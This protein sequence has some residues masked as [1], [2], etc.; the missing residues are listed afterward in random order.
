[1]G[2]SSLAVPVLVSWQLLSVTGLG[3][4]PVQALVVR[5][6]AP[7]IEVLGSEDVGR[8]RALAAAFPDEDHLDEVSPRLARDWM[9]LVYDGP[10]RLVVRM[11][12]DLPDGIVR[13]TLLRDA[14]DDGILWV[15]EDTVSGATAGVLDWGRGGP[16]VRELLFRRL[17]DASSEE[18]KEQVLEELRKELTKGGC[19]TLAVSVRGIRT[20]LDCDAPPREL[21]ESLA[22]GWAEYLTPAERRRLGTVFRLLHHGAAQLLESPEMSVNPMLVLA[23]VRLPLEPLGLDS[24]PGVRIRQI[25]PSL[26]DG[27][28][29]PGF[30]YPDGPEIR[31]LAGRKGIVPSDMER[32]FA[33]WIRALF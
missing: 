22:D 31:R 2:L 28:A 4:R 19:R 29:V 17:F 9:Q 5:E 20:P 10:T 26:E 30:V 12:V 6:E 3:P 33:R 1:M 16:N 8:L 7:C 23:G 11:W 14:A 21:A 24:G 27:G 18:E 13:S 15:V 25:R 32:S